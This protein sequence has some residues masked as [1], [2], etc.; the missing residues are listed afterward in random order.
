MRVIKPGETPEAARRLHYGPTLAP[1]TGWPGAHPESG[2]AVPL[3]L[4]ASLQAPGWS[5][6]APCGPHGAT[7]PGHNHGHAGP[8]GQRRQRPSAR[9]RATCGL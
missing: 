2:V 9:A 6:S 5:G 1:R 8:G 4:W 7:R 3:P